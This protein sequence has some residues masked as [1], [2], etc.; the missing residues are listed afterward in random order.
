MFSGVFFYRVV[1]R[2]VNLAVSRD[3]VRWCLTLLYISCFTLAN[4]SIDMTKDNFSCF[5]V[6]LLASSFV[7]RATR[8][9]L[10]WHVFF[11]LTHVFYLRVF[12]SFYNSFI[13]FTIF[14]VIEMLI[15]TAVMSMR[16]YINPAYIILRLWKIE[17]T[18]WIRRPSL[19]GFQIPHYF[20]ILLFLAWKF[21]ITSITQIQHRIG[22]RHQTVPSHTAKYVVHEIYVLENLLSNGNRSMPDNSLVMYSGNVTKNAYR[23]SPK[24]PESSI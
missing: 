12:C 3:D 1:V 15:L 4:G 16:L 7:R 18:F 19:I 9:F 11:C 13:I 23:I 24:R 17:N 8:F 22:E 5:C 6:F 2:V 14:I 21:R 10:V 20:F